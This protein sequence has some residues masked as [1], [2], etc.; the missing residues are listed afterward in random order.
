VK[1]WALVTVVLYFIVASVI[2]TPPLLLLAGADRESIWAFYVWFLPV[3]SLV[4]VA[5]LAIPVKVAG[6]R[7]VGRR[8]ALFSALVCAI[9]MAVLL[10]AFVYCVLLMLFGEDGVD[11]FFPLGP[12]VIGVSALWIAW[13]VFFFR[14]FSPDA[15]ETFTRRVSRWLLTGSILE[16]LV[17]VPAHIIS[18]ERE[19]CCAPGFTLFGL[20]TG[21]AVAVLAFGP[22]VFFLLAGRVREKRRASI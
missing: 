17:A 21:L 18:R 4:Q 7:P 15:P 6:G 19:E 22:A 11:P 10:L 1:R 2:V 3:L 13:A 20:A 12:T 9:P 14:G 5:L 16:L 8:T